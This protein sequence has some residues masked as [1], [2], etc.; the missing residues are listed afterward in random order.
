MGWQEWLV[1]LAN[2]ARNLRAY[3]LEV[4]D[5]CVS[6][7]MAGREKDFTFIKELLDRGLVEMETLIEH[8]GLVADIP[9]G[10]ALVPRLERRSR[11]ETLKR[12]ESVGKDSTGV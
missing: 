12:N 2:E 6:K 4:H 7:L 10:D 5:T 11:R 8:A 9:Q 3:G 1:P